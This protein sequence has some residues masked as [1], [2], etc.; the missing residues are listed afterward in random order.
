MT[1][2]TTFTA[3]FAGGRVPVAEESPAGATARTVVARV[4]VEA[5]ISTDLRRAR[6]PR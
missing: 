5:T 2:G 6:A 1:W 3:G 4:R